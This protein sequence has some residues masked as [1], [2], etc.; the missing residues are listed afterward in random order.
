MKELIGSTIC[1]IEGKEVQITFGWS[2]DKIVIFG[3]N[4]NLGNWV[5]TDRKAINEADAKRIV[6]EYLG[7]DN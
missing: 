5:S 3:E 6:R 2:E 4:P 7:Q 1:V